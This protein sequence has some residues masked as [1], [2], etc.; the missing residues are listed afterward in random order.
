MN[1]YPEDQVIDVADDFMYSQTGAVKA[2]RRGKAT[3]ALWKLE[4]PFA[5]YTNGPTVHYQL[6]YRWH[7]S[8]ESAN[9]EITGSESF[10]WQERE[11]ADLRVLEPGASLF[12]CFSLFA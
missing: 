3:L 6:I 8:C 12:D 5:L 11:I 4:W 9:S 7:P 2:Q 10:F 1:T